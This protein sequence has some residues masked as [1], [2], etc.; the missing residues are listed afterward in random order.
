MQR[1]TLPDSRHARQAEAALCARRSHGYA[2]APF[3]SP[4]AIC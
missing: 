4:A 1:G 3:S 2:P